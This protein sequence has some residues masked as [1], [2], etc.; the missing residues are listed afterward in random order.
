[1]Y[2]LTGERVM[3]L[4]MN[5]R[6]SFRYDD[7]TDDM[8]DTALAE[9]NWIN[10]GAFSEDDD[11]ATYQ[12]QSFPGTLHDQDVRCVVV[13]S[14][15]LKEQAENRIEQDLETTEEDLM[16]AVDQLGD[17]SFACEED[18]R[19][20]AAE[21]LAAHDQHCFEIETDVVEKVALC[22]SQL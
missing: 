16:D 21:W 14:S 22:W 10:L 15:S 1:M 7:F 18:A 5:D 2:S 6:H 20:A 13:R 3:A 12:I 11:A 4:I 17:R 9:D 19:D 8:I